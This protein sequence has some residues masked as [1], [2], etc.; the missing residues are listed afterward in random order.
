MSRF[1]VRVASFLDRVGRPSTDEAFMCP[2]RFGARRRAAQG[3]K[4]GRIMTVVSDFTHLN[5]TFAAGITIGDSQT[6]WE[7]E[8]DTGGR[9]TGTALLMMQ[10]SGLTFATQGARVEVNG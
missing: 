1:G 10:V 8:F 3:G 9:T 6:S 4:G 7:T 5:A 2:S